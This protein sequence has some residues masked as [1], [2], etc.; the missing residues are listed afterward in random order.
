MPGY[1]RVEVVRALSQGQINKLTNAQLKEALGTLM[2]ENTNDDDAQPS[3]AVLLEE[4]RNLRD[5]ISQLKNM[6]HEV[7]QLTTKLEDAYK[8]INHQQKFLETLD[9]RNRRENIILTGVEEK[10]NAMG[11]G[12]VAKVQSVLQ[13]AGV[14]DCDPTTWEMMRLGQPD[15]R[16]KRP[17][18]I[19][20]RSEAERDKILRQAKQLK[21]AGRLYSSIYINKDLHP[22]VRKELK[23]LRDREKEEKNKPEN[24]GVNIMYDWRNRVLLRDGDVID[25]YSPSFY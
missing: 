16:K 3:N 9:A 8:I 23:R 2:N 13:A 22:A 19:K 15:E 25:K 11:A 12:D 7:E 10:D 18:R 1:N 17:I 21:G 24:A 5:E 14:T 6:K 20:V 4:I